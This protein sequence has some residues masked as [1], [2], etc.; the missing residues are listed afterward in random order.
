MTDYYITP[1][2][3]R[4]K[5]GNTIAGNFSSSIID[6]AIAYGCDE[7]DSRTKYDWINGGKYFGLAQG[8]AISFAAAFCHSTQIN[9][10]IQQLREWQMAVD[11][12]T[13]FYGTLLSEGLIR[14]ERT[15]FVTD[16]YQTEVLNP[17]T[18]TRVTGLYGIVRRNRLLNYDDILYKP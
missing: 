8:I 10:S 11:D 9:V 13:A 16:D 18:G 5:L 7:V 12:C 6:K 14:K 17:V 3:V 2:N 15:M 1:Q 4:D